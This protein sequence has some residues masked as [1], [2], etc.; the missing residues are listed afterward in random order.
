[1]G[2]RPLRLNQEKE[3]L[4]PL[5]EEVYTKAKK[6]PRKNAKEIYNPLPSNIN[7]K[8]YIQESMDI[9]AFAF[10]RSTLVLTKGSTLLLNDDNLKGLIAHELGHFANRDTF[11]ALC[12]SIAN[13]PMS[14]SLRLLSIARTKMEE[15]GKSSLAVR[16]VR[17]FIDMF[18]YGFKGVEFVGDLIIMHS[19]RRSEYEADLYAH[20]LKY[21]A[22]LAEV[23]TQIYQISMEKPKS[24]GEMVRASHPHL[25]KRVE[26]LEGV[27]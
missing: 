4:L 18:Y 9:N 13:L 17:G 5:F 14:L 16:V 24:V 2:V 25:T 12:A 6:K 10:G 23:L 11:Y 19:R 27:V 15:S 3:R 1:M 22:E 21:G 8:L 26:R 7:I 20:K